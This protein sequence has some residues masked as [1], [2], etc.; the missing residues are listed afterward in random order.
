M[1]RTTVVR[2]QSNQ[3]EMISSCVRWRRDFVGATCPNGDTYDNGG[4]C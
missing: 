3:R 4:N 1:I 2:E